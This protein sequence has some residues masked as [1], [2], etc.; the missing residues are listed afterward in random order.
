MPATIIKGASADLHAAPGA[1]PG[2]HATHA[3]VKDASVVGEIANFMHMSPESLAAM[4]MYAKMNAFHRYSHL[5]E[6]VRKVVQPVYAATMRAGLLAGARGERPIHKAIREVVA[7]GL[8]PNLVKMYEMGHSAGSAVAGLPQSGVS[9]AVSTLARKLEDVREALPP[10]AAGYLSNIGDFVKDVSTDNK[11]SRG[12]RAATGLPEH[13]DRHLAGE[14]MPPHVSED[15]R[16]IKNK[17]QTPADLVTRIQA[18][19]F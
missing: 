4:A 12:I 14:W 1:V 9:G 6:P 17:P 15:W 13:I 3:L 5:L 18:R 8:D 19:A 16:Y 2:A 11:L 7:V 10:G